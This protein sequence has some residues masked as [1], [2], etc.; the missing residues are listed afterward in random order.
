MEHPLWQ[1]L[2][3]ETALLEPADDGLSALDLLAECYINTCIQ[4]QINIYPGTKLNKSHLCPLLYL[5]FFFGITHNTAGYG[6][7]DL[8]NHNGFPTAVL[9]SYG[10]PL[11]FGRSLGKVGS[12]KTATVMATIPNNTCQRIPV[13]VHVKNIHKHGD[14]YGFPF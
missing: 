4:R 14:L 9:Q 13:D 3:K 7:S 2:L 1:N 12:H 11:I 10:G 5:G 6:T 8:S